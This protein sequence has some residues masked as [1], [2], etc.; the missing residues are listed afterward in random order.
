MQQIKNKDMETEFPKN[1]NVEI[2]VEL[3]KNKTALEDKRALT[4]SLLEKF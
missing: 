3:Q 2:R 4:Q 1:D